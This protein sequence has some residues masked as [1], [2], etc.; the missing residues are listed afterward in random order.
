M[1]FSAILIGYT[2]YKNIKLSATMML[3]LELISVSMIIVVIVLTIAHHAPGVDLEQLSLHGANPGNVRAGLVIAVFGFAA[4]ESSA[5]LGQKPETRCA[6]SRRRSCAA[7]FSA[8]S[9]SSSRHTP[10][11]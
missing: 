4:F 10:W 6:P 8:D 2:G 11:S 7:S 3:W 5:S 1:L 9:S